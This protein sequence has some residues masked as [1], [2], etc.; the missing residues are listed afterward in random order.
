MH[1]KTHPRPKSNEQTNGGLTELSEDALRAVSGGGTN[2]YSDV[3]T[4]TYILRPA[5]QVYVGP[6]ILVGRT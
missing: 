2:I 6:G 3:S 1:N 4:G 5:G